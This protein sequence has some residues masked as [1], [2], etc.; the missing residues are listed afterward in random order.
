MKTL[1]LPNLCTTAMLKT[2]AEGFAGSVAQQRLHAIFKKKFG[3]EN[4]GENDLK[5]IYVGFNNIVSPSCTW[6]NS[7]WVCSIL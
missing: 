2:P 3:R 4:Y 6:A 1:F 5:N 7:L